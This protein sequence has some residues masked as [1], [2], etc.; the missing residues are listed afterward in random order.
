MICVC[1]CTH[2]HI[3]CFCVCS[4]LYIHL[5]AVLR[6]NFFYYRCYL[7]SRGASEHGSLVFCFSKVWEAAGLQGNSSSLQCFV[8][9][10]FPL[11][12]QQIGLSPII[13]PKFYK[14]KLKYNSISCGEF[15]SQIRHSFFNPTRQYKSYKNLCTI[16]W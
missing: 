12:C 16:L 8:C 5:L 2:I 3:V 14:D 4:M 10:P 13:S 7:E 11:E 6:W 9:V 15:V 1:M